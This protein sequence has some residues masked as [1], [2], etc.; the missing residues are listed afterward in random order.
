MKGDFS[1]AA[2]VT[3]PND[4]GL[5]FQQGRVIA[6]RDLTEAELIAHA[7]RE[8]AARDII[9]A[10][11]AA[12]PAGTGD[13]YRVESA[14]I[15]GDHVDVVLHPGRIWADGLSVTLPTAAGG[16]SP[17]IAASYLA[18][19]AN[20]AGTGVDSIG[21]GIRDAVILEIAVDALNGFQD[22]ARLIEPALGGPDTAE[23]LHAEQRLHLLRL[24]PGEDCTT[25]R[26]RLA[27]DLS[28]HGRLSVTLEE[29]VQIAGDC[30]VVEGG[31]YSGFEH[32]LY[33]IE[34]AQTNGA[35]VMFKW[36]SMNGGLV[37]R[38]RFFGGADPRVQITANR[39]AIL[40]TG[41]TDYYLEAL[42]F[43]AHLG[44]WR[45]VYGTTA[46]LNADG[47]I[48]LATPATFG[49]LPGGG[50]TVFFRLWNGVQPIAPFAGGATPFRD[51]IELHF[52]SAPASYRPGD[53]WTFD[54]RAGEIDNPETLH[55]NAPPQG[56]ALRR[57]PLAEINWTAQGDTTQG[58]TIEDCR[59]RFRPLTNQKVC[60]TWLVGNGVTTFGDFDS[61]EEAVAHLPEAGGQICLLPGIHLAN[62]RLDG[63][64]DIRIH[65]CRDRTL[66]LP[67][68]AS[69]ADPVIAIRGGQR[70]EI[71]DLD[72]F[73]PFGIAIRARGSEKSPLRGLT[74][75]GCRMLAL[76]HGIH[77]DTAEAV[78]LRD[79]RIWM[80]DHILALTAISL[81]A[82]DALVAD[83]TLAVWPLEFKPPI[84][85]GDDDED[86]PDP[87]DPCIEPEDLYGNLMLV[88]T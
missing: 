2:A 24:G 57:V 68:F 14:A 50:G 80:L 62:L 49:T 17:V 58:G 19:P 45:V 6:D 81:R 7:W 53:H 78:T 72:F 39:T 42:E 85:G 25:I 12:L 75:R 56:P 9:G 61:L 40:T 18:P 36:S 27:D 29:P 3:S 67:R 4:L 37:G 52:P 33:R 47:D 48:D 1:K 34:I 16:G 88:A 44:H 74:V 66:V 64:H 69:F 55:D 79:N 31:G 26:D 51:G 46:T 8:T 65:G 41:F 30:P 87:A 86:P 77:I 38:G 83:N 22:V 32:N 70:I 11:V 28:T 73:A 13:G 43:S 60:C 54:L 10:G 5:L 59:R 84:P 71:A 21:P 23:R 82:T 76:T 15:H 63:R 35:A 20:P